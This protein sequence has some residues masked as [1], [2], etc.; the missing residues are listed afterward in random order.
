MTTTFAPQWDTKL[1][2][3]LSKATLS[4]GMGSRKDPCSLAA[5]NLAITGELIDTVPA[6]MSRVVGT[7]I[8]PIQDAMPAEMRNSPQWKEL[9]PLA[10]GTGR[11]HELLWARIVL[12]WMWTAVLPELQPTADDIGFGKAWNKMCKDRTP[13]Q[14]MEAANEAMRWSRI[15]DEATSAAS[16]AATHAQSALIAFPKT[17]GEVTVYAPEAVN[18]V[19]DA[20]TRTSEAARHASQEQLWERFDPCSLLERL[21]KPVQPDQEDQYTP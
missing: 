9:L 4:K 11:D 1:R 17:P 15:D 20:A 7:W 21:C 10:A 3:I 8:I 6:C 5:I 13:A 18:H 2:N 14:A 12:D 16:S 19:G